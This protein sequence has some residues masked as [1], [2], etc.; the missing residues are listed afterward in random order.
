MAITYAGAI[1]GGVDSPGTSRYYSMAVPS[2]GAGDFALFAIVRL[3]QVWLDDPTVT[4]GNVI[5]VV[6]NGTTV[7]TGGN[8]CWFRFSPSNSGSTKL[9]LS[10]RL[11]R[12]G[13]NVMSSGTVLTGAANGI[14]RGKTYVL[15]LQ[16]LSGTVSLKSCE[17]GGTVV[18]HASVARNGSFNAS[19]G[20]WLTG[21]HS[22]GPASNVVYQAFGLAA[23]EAFSDA[24][25]EAI[26]DGTDPETY[27][28]A[29]ARTAL[30]LFDSL[31]ATIAPAWGTPG[32]A[33]R[34]GTWTNGAV[35]APVIANATDRIEVTNQPDLYGFITPGQDATV[36]ASHTWTGT[37]AGITPATF[38]YRLEELDGT[39]VVD[40]TNLSSFTAAAGSWSGV[41]SLPPG[42]LYRIRFRDSV[43]TTVTWT[44]QVPF[45]VGPVVA[46]MGQS[47]FVF[48]ETEYKSGEVPADELYVMCPRTLSDVFV[49]KPLTGQIG[50][51][52]AAMSQR[53]NA[54]APGV[55]LLA[56]A[57]AEDGTSIANWASGAGGWP[58][59]L[60]ALTDAN[61]SDVLLSWQNGSSDLGTS[62]ATIKSG[63]DTLYALIE[64]E[65]ETGLGMTFRFRML[66]FNRN[67]GASAVDAT[68]VRVAQREWAE[69]HVDFGSRVLLGPW[70][71]DMQAD[72]EDTGTAIAGSN[73][74]ITLASTMEAFASAMN[75]ATI[76]ILSGTG[77]GQT[78]TVSSYNPGTRVATVSSNWTTNPDATSVYAVYGTSPHPDR[79]GTERFGPPLA[80]DT[81]YYFDLAT[82]TGVGPTVASATYP[83]GGDGSIIDV[84]FT[85]QGSST[86]TNHDGV[87]VDVAG[88]DVSD[89]SFA[90]TETITEVEIT[91]S[92]TVRITLSGAPG[93]LASLQVR[94]GYGDVVAAA[95][96]YKTAFGL[97]T[98]LIDDSLASR[99]AMFT[100]APVSVTE[101]PPPG[102]GGNRMGGT[103]AIRKPPRR[104]SAR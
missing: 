6:N 74:T 88:F 55:P 98:I 31:G 49:Y 7:G 71:G 103:G 59:F 51:G 50:A 79:I 37:Y 32:D 63:L 28:T 100:D 77:S 41:A 46:D 8:D 15:V 45:N 57:T 43:A 4:T 29:G 27:I 101:A 96:W 53:W 72:I 19:L 40:W 5:Y 99:V 44:S 82:E 64:T 11:S 87:T 9:V 95:D 18:T 81:A 90:T 91:G 2:T 14:E 20:T 52:Y 68:K 102:G 89:D 54:V 83:N 16:S 104:T 17:L 33:T 66:P 85:M 86:L 22:T 61:V 56:L 60:S 30:W 80:Q 42:G 21:A 65:V 97:G 70:W 23:G 3:P 94:Y 73:N 39:Q 92:N 76:I 69:D 48:F 25:I 62:A 34:V 38:Q 10:G 93:T 84:A 24:E 75:G 1:H 26:A 67:P 47:P 12:A 35:T 78:R 36:N 58:E 13:T